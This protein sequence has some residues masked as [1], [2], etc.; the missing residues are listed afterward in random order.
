MH[1]SDLGYF[2]GSV[3]A[4]LILQEAFALTMA[5]DGEIAVCTWRH[6]R[7]LLVS[8]RERRLPDFDAAVADVQAQGYTVCIRSFGGLAVPLDPGVVCVTAC[9]P[10][11]WGQHEAFSDLA[12]LLAQAAARWCKAEVGEV[13]GAYCPG[14]FDIATGGRKWAGIAQRRVRGATLVSAFVNVEPN[15]QRAAVVRAFY[16]R[17]CACAPP[18]VLVRPERVGSLQ[19]VATSGDAHA[20]VLASTDLLVAIVSVLEDWGARCHRFARSPGDEVVE[21]VRQR[22]EAGAGTREWIGFTGL[23]R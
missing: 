21:S 17:A 3:Q 20:G 12:A 5:G 19:E 22:Y 4:A 8:A 9:G 16:A 15:P 10:Q 2:A 23:P 13:P 18:P 1:V 7:A 6:A 14:R 11:E